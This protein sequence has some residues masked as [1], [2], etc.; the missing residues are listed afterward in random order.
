MFYKK[1]LKVGFDWETIITGLPISVYWKDRNGCYLGCNLQ[2]A[3]HVGVSS[4]EE[5]VGMQD[6]D[7]PWTKRKAHELMEFD[8]SVMKLKKAIVV[9]KQERYAVKM[10]L[11]NTNGDLVGIFGFLLDIEKHKEAIS[12]EL[13]VLD[14]IIAIMPGHV[15][16]KDRNCVLQGCNELQ[17]KDSGLSSRKL[18]V[19]KTAYDLLLQ[20][21]PEEEKQHQAAT[22]NSYDEEVMKYDKTMTFEEHVV[23][24]NKSVATFLSKKTPLHDAYGNVTGLVGISFDITDRKK[25][26]EF[27]KCAKEQ[28]EAAN[29]SKIEFLENMR[30]DIRTPLTGIIGFAQL[31]KQEASNPIIKEYADNLVM[32]TTALLDFQNEILDAIKVSQGNIP[33][34]EHKFSLKQI[35]KKVLDLVR[36]KAILKQ[37]PIYFYYDEQLPEFFHG[38]S[39]RLFRILLELMTN[40]LK[41]T[42]AGHIRLEL[43]LAEKRDD[44]IT[45]HC[46]VTDTGIG[47]PD[48]KKEEIFIRFQ[49]LSPSSDG[50]YEGTGLGLT[51]VK[52][53]V[54]E[55][56]GKISVNSAIN[57]GTTFICALPLRMA[58][59]VIEEKI[60]LPEVPSWNKTCSVLL[61]E[62]HT[63]TATVTKLMLQEL[64]CKVDVA[65]NA[66]S[67]LLNTQK[68]QY[69]LIFM[70]LGLPDCNGFALT[71]K[72]RAQHTETAQRAVIVALTAHKEEDSEKLCIA[73]GMDAILQKPLIKSTAINLLNF[74]FADNA[75]KIPIIDLALGAKRIHQDEMAA[76]SMLDLLI[77]HIDEDQQHIQSAFQKKDFSRLRDLIHKLLG[78]LAYCGAPRLESSCI[79]LQNALK[80]ENISDIQ[81]CTQ[82]LLTEIH[83]LKKQYQ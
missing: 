33:V 46:K 32:A 69:D 21:Q 25:T 51:M 5:V 47:I 61:V 14:E 29:R 15:Y 38:D 52:Q 40:A 68:E 42:A 27:L 55:L 71:Q 34:D 24:P 83:V 36:P 44:L 11:K 63:M 79:E 70:D 6:T 43:C 50:V 73:A 56:G 28:A 67:A 18:I 54:E 2:Y 53:F 31:I 26:E 1:K 72:M 45:L 77:Q 23:L 64:G 58:S 81:I 8:K 13:R 76:K 62:D 30:H 9:E 80:N 19:G 49:R 16:W 74:Y 17:A 82:R 35:S 57:Q 48:E 75:M 65:S 39:K 12:H 3:E 60:N 10:P 66:Q 7:L 41:F 4:I 20:D 59:D 22:T 78:G 37:L